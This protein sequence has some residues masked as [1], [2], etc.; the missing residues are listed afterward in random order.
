[1][2][3]KYLEELWNAYLSRRLR[4]S[5]PQQLSLLQLQSSWAHSALVFPIWDQRQLGPCSCA[6]EPEGSVH[7]QSAVQN[8]KWMQSRIKSDRAKPSQAEAAA[9]WKSNE[10]QS[11]AAAAATLIVIYSSM[12]MGPLAW[13]RPSISRFLALQFLS[14]HFICH[15]H[16][17][18]H[19][20]SVWHSPGHFLPAPLF[21]QNP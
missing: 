4:L 6:L 14:D 12:V 5:Q 10:K 21:P 16:P 20:W 8:G 3:W 13:S 11:S 2:V 7:L 19:P 17:S 1:M 18:I 9:A 15:R